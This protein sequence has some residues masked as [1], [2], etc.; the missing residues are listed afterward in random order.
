MEFLGAK[1]SS[2]GYSSVCSIADAMR[3][4]LLT[5]VRRKPR[6]AVGEVDRG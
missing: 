3:S 2:V 5:G 6:L 1:S 4:H